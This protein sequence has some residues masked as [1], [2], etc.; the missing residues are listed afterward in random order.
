VK[1]S[2]PVHNAWEAGWF[3]EPVWTFWKREKP[4]APPWIRTPDSPVHSRIYTNYAISAPVFVKMYTNSSRTAGVE[5]LNGI[6]PVNTKVVLL[7]N[8]LSIPCDGK[9]VLSSAFS[10]TVDGVQ[11]PVQW[12][13]D[14]ISHGAKTTG[15]E[16]DHSS[17]SSDEVR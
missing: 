16:T 11:P 8:R 4:L 1:I 17:L 5:Y 6:S 15:P 3:S 9:D 14:A 2:T 7:R 10:L 12:L 13:T